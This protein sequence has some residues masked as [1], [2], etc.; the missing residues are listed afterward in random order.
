MT[1]Y[2]KFFFV[3][4]LYAIE[5]TKYLAQAHVNELKAS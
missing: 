3:E 1:K 5:S 4:K 2:Q